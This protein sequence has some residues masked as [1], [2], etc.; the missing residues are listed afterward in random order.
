MSDFTNGLDDG[1]IR[2][3]ET[4]QAMQKGRNIQIQ[5]AVLILVIQLFFFLIPFWP[6]R[7]FLAVLLVIIIALNWRRWVDWSTIP[8]AVNPAHPLMELSSD[9]KAKVMIRLHDGRWE[10][11]GE[12]RYRL[13]EDDLLK[14]F[15]LVMLDDKY[16]I[17][18]YFTDEKSLSSSLR[19][20]IALLNQSLAL[21]DAHNGEHDDIE[22]ARKRESIDFGL[23]EREWPDEEDSQD[24]LGPIAKKLKG[25]E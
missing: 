17:F 25:Q 8:F 14:G 4:P 21:R 18:G 5:S 12:Y 3:S 10:L 15:N 9:K 13:V 23:L 2:F 1:F 6:I 24:A 22:D 7:V 19:R 11:A 16:S 20:T